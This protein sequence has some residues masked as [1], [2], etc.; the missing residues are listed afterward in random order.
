METLA[1]LGTAL[2]LALLSGINLYLTVMLTGLAVRFD[3]LDL[4]DRYQG[5]A[6]FGNGWIIG[7]AA[8]LYAIEFVADKVPWIDSLWDT[9]HTVIR[10]VGGAVLALA[11]LGHM[12]PT[13]TVAAALLF[14]GVSLSTHSAKATVRGALNLS[15]EPV[16]NSVAS[17]AEDG[18]VLAG[19]GLSAWLPAIAF[20][21]FLAL[22]IA[23]LF[24]TRKLLGWV[25]RRK[26]EKG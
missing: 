22:V 26:V 23:A 18:L 25:R 7:L 5:L 17:L 20:F 11:A 3:L 13:L 9:V 24:I 6:V 21:V 8:V 10:P 19:F 14:G 2:G 1:L 12:D 15:P 4:A 16:S